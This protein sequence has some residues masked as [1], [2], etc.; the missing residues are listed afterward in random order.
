MN[1]IIICIQDKE[2]G[3]VAMGQDRRRWR[4]HAGQC[5]RCKA[6]EA[7]RVHGRSTDISRNNKM[8][9][10]EALTRMAPDYVPVIYR[11]I[12]RALCENG[13]MNK[14]KPPTLLAGAEECL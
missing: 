9:E 2:D 8:T 11:R 14:L 4:D 3:S 13:P 5:A 12:I 10:Q 7:R 6:F 1:T